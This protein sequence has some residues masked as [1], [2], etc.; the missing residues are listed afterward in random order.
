MVLRGMFS[1]EVAYEAMGH[2]SFTLKG[3]SISALL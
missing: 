3:M 2:G 1:R